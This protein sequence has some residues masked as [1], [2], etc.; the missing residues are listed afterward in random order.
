MEN[1]SE[2]SQGLDRLLGRLAGRR[3][4]KPRGGLPRERFVTGEARREHRGLIASRRTLTVLV[5]LGLVYACVDL[6]FPLGALGAISAL[7]VAAAVVLLVT[8]LS[9]IA[10][11]AGTHYEVQYKTG[12]RQLR[13]QRFEPS[14]GRFADV[15]LP[16]IVALLA[17]L[18]AFSSLHAW[19][20]RG[21]AGSYSE[22]LSPLAAVYYSLSTFSRAAVD[23]VPLSDGAR[24]LTGVQ[25]I[26]GWL[27][28]AV[29][30]ATILAWLIRNLRPR[31]TSPATAW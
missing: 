1:S 16:L 28:G 14:L 7:T 21:F 11:G 20:S 8:P 30:V 10:L 19:L 4:A 12:A 22:A 17:Q 23:I 15:L 24:A 29:V 25:A 18:A 31:R 26:L 6:L 13:K 9:E 5:S 27:A 3:A 2:E